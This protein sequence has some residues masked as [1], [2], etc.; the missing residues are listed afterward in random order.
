MQ[1]FVFYVPTYFFWKLLLMCSR[2]DFISPAHIS[3]RQAADGSYGDHS[4][5]KLS[6][7]FFCKQPF[8]LSRPCSTSS[9]QLS[10]SLPEVVPMQNSHWQPQTSP[11]HFTR[12]WQ[13]S[14]RKMSGHVIIPIVCL[15]L[16]YS[17]YRWRCKYVGTVSAELLPLLLRIRDVLTFLELLTVTH[18]DWQLGFV[19]KGG[20]TQKD[21]TVTVAFLKSY[22]K[23]LFSKQINKK[24]LPVEE[25]SVLGSPEETLKI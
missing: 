17:T 13:T 3:G 10:C 12:L 21:K 4:H 18:P 15:E 7:L 24:R 22:L 14:P 1:L 2:S 5:T 11:P 25:R 9:L 20:D 19:N 6:L 16:H 8:F 23:P